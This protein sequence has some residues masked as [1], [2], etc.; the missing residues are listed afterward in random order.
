MNSR[1]SECVKACEGIPSSILSTPGYSIAAELDN[2]DQQ[3][4]LRFR[5]QQ[6]AM[7]LSD[8]IKAAL[9]DDPGWRRLCVDALAK[10]E[11][12]T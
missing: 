10:A 9:A 11:G 12:R 3:I 4:N 8:A 7:D 5:A 1:E 6:Q 2:L